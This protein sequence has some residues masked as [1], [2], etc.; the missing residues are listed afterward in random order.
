M[1]NRDQINY[2]PV[3]VNAVNLARHVFHKDDEAQLEIPSNFE[4]LEVVNSKDNTLRGNIYQNKS[5]GDLYIA[6]RGSDNITNW[7][8]DNSQLAYNH[9]LSNAVI[10]FKESVQR[11]VIECFPLMSNR[12]I[13]TGYSL[14]API[15]AEIGLRNGYEVI[16]WDSPGVSKA[17]L[18]DFPAGH[19]IWKNLSIYQGPNNY[20]NDIYNA[21]VE[22]K[23]LHGLNDT[24]SDK[25]LAGLLSVKYANNS[26]KYQTV[27]VKHIQ[28]TIEYHSI[29]KIS[30][31]VNTQASM[32]EGLAS[33]KQ[34][35]QT[36]AKSLRSLMNPARDMRMPAV[37][38]AEDILKPKP[39]EHA[40]ISILKT[41]INQAP[42]AD[43]ESAPITSNIVKADNCSPDAQKDLAR[44]QARLEFQKEINAALNEVRAGKEIIG[45]YEI[46]L[47]KSQKSNVNQ[48]KEVQPE[49]HLP[50]VAAKAA[51]AIANGLFQTARIIDQSKEAKEL[52]DNIIRN[53]QQISSSLEF[54]FE[55]DKYANS[56]IPLSLLHQ[57]LSRDIYESLSSNLKEKYT[58]F[59][60][61]MGEIQQARDAISAGDLNIEFCRNTIDQIGAKVKKAYRKLNRLSYNNSAAYVSTGATLFSSLATAAHSVGMINPFVAVG[62]SFIAAIG[63][64]IQDQNNTRHQKRVAKYQAELKDL[65]NKQEQIYQIQEKSEAH[66]HEYVSAIYQLH[67]MV[68]ACGQYADPSEFRKYLDKEIATS[69][70]NESTLKAE[71]ELIQT[72]IDSKNNQINKLEDKLKTLNAELEAKQ[73][74]NGSRKKK[75]IEKDIKVTTKDLDKAKDGSDV[76]LATLGYQLISV[77]T[78]ITSASEMQENLVKRKKYEENTKNVNDWYYNNITKP[79]LVELKPEQQRLADIEHA[80]TERYAELVNTIKANTFAKDITIDSLKNLANALSIFGIKKPELFMNGIDLINQMNNIFLVLEP[81][82]S[83]FISLFSDVVDKDGLVTRKAVETFYDACKEFGGIKLSFIS[84]ASPSINLIALGVKLVALLS[85]VA[86]KNDVIDAMNDHFRHLGR[87]LD[88]RLNQISQFI[89]KMDQSILAEMHDISLDLQEIKFELKNQRRKLMDVQ[90]EIIK[91]NSMRSDQTNNLIHEHHLLTNKNVVLSYENIV[92]SEIEKSERKLSAS[93]HKTDFNQILKDLDQFIIRAIQAKDQCKSSMGISIDFDAVSIADKPYEYIDIIANKFDSQH[94][95]NNLYV[96]FHLYYSN[97]RNTIITLERLQK[98]SSSIGQS[99][100]EEISKKLSSVLFEG[101]R[102]SAFL[103]TSMSCS[104]PLFNIQIDNLKNKYKMIELEYSRQYLSNRDKQLENSRLRYLERKQS[105]LSLIRDNILNIERNTINNLVGA[106]KFLLNDLFALELAITTKF[107]YDQFIANRSIVT[108]GEVALSVITLGIYLLANENMSTASHHKAKISSIFLDNQ[109]AKE[110]SLYD[111][112][113]K[114]HSDQFD[115]SDNEK[116]KY[117]LGIIYYNPQLKKFEMGS[118]VS[119]ESQYAK[120]Q[121]L[122]VEIDENIDIKLDSTKEEI[123]EFNV[124]M[125]QRRQSGQW[126]QPVDKIQS[127]SNFHN[128]PL[129]IEFSDY[130]ARKEL[131]LMDKGNLPIDECNVSS[132]RDVL[133]LNDNIFIKRIPLVPIPYPSEIMQMKVEDNV[134]LDAKKAR[135]DDYKNK[136]NNK[137]EQYLRQY[138][139]IIRSLI[140][141]NNY[142]NI[143]TSFNKLNITDGVLV[144]STKPKELFPMIIPASLLQDIKINRP[145]IS[146]LYEEESKGLGSVNLYYSLEKESDMNG[147]ETYNLRLVYKLLASD[148]SENLLMAASKVIFKFDTISVEIFK[149]YLPSKKK[150]IKSNELINLNEFLLLAM[151]GSRGPCG[152]PCNDTYIFSKEFIC[153]SELRFIGLYPVLEKISSDQIFY[154]DHKNYTNEMVNYFDEFVKTGKIENNMDCFFIKPTEELDEFMHCNVEG[155]LAAE[156]VLYKLPDFKSIVS[157]NLNQSVNLYSQLKQEYQTLI[158]LLKLNINIS[159]MHAEELLHLKTGII[160]PTIFTN[161]IFTN[162]D[163]FISFLKTQSELQ[164]DKSILLPFIKD[165][166]SMESSLVVE[167]NSLNSQLQKWILYLAHPNDAC[168]PVELLNPW[169]KRPNRWEPAP[170]VKISAPD[171]IKSDQPVVNLD[172]TSIKTAEHVNP[173]TNGQEGSVERSAFIASFNTALTHAMNRFNSQSMHGMFRMN[174]LAEIAKVYGLVC[175][176]VPG[177]GNCFY[178]AIVDQLA[179]LDIK[180]YTHLDL[181]AMVIKELEANPDHYKYIIQ[182]DLEISTFIARHKQSGHFAEHVSLVALAKALN[183]IIVILSDVPQRAPD[184]IRPRE[185]IGT[186]YI[187]LHVNAQHYVSLK[188]D[189]QCNLPARNFAKLIKDAN[190]L[191]NYGDLLPIRNNNL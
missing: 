174:P 179:K 71:K 102:L 15:A 76:L 27:M 46:N 163:V 95:A 98:A 112:L 150:A 171:E 145:K 191:A 156:K 185:P 55:L 13:C 16:V 141:E 78:S 116:T 125:E 92:L 60:K 61:L 188:R 14:G 175:K 97:V 91:L 33:F 94:Q 85:G 176:N 5:N 20:V 190:Y 182:N 131:F 59:D 36:P 138:S 137:M 167:L 111:R 107:N 89:H 128:Y 100:P 152:L 3:M 54:K 40:P 41:N 159:T 66:N 23:R 168:N 158:A 68:L 170:T 147:K 67:N 51:I 99:L 43:S 80:A 127:P 49:T 77:G 183:I 104:S 53:C 119:L 106:D 108:A 164:I 162:Y 96:N 134:T 148:N 62:F 87:H 52:K 88:E 74:G 83:R 120:Y 105:E 178:H 129:R 154:Y 12:I 161:H 73:H 50:E 37:K 140:E 169:D 30:N 65:M 173:E 25:A 35:N 72:Q 38:K 160:N 57:Q 24:N 17:L 47:L 81:S 151:Y 11:K 124:E 29:V 10:E 58:Y 166:S 18:R 79:Q 122:G 110:G 113:R 82:Y 181:R 117:P 1:N 135:I 143:R 109:T 31:H 22:I 44:E 90:D 184:I 69:K 93:S 130:N 101:N 26:L 19:P 48:D 21:P 133:V 187:G 126:V 45:S 32:Q 7:M 6:I 84:L 8:R 136:Y 86:P 123:Q 177:D 70:T 103:R 153:P 155:I 149:K 189:K 186:A 63:T 180:D 118:Y 146:K 139:S 28:D 115:S 4:L 42:Q 34:A 39:I 9:D 75:D 144:S 121:K 172:P 142:R 114:L 165:I 157:S 64:H 56:G 2:T 132:R